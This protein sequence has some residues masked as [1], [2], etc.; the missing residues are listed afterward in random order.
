MCTKLYTSHK[1]Q[2]KQRAERTVSNTGS[3][4][5]I[6]ITNCEIRI[7]LNQLKSRAG[8][9]KNK[10]A[11]V[12]SGCNRIEQILKVLFNKIIEEGKTYRFSLIQKASQHHRSSA[13]R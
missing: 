10:V 1:Q 3:E 6:E 8:E 9:D 13:N 7:P 4:E 11:M 2:E 5:I 12:K